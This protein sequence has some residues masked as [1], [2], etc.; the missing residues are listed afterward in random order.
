[1]GPRCVVQY[2]DSVGA[3]RRATA[4]PRTPA[5]E[6]RDGLEMGPRCVVRREICSVEAAACWAAFWSADRRC[7]DRIHKAISSGEGLGDPGCRFPS[8]WRQTRA[9]PVPL[10]FVAQ[11]LHSNSSAAVLGNA[12]GSHHNPRTSSA[13]VI[14]SSPGGGDADA[15]I[16]LGDARRRRTPR[17]C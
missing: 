5:G 13:E 3:A 16:S 2:R 6:A 12:K 7:L 1:M 4:A 15:N 17:I 10:Q 8:R 11:Q 14:H 9:P